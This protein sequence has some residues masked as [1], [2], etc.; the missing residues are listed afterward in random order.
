MFEDFNLKKQDMRYL[1]GLLIFNAI[2]VTYYINFNV[3]LGISCS[4]V[5][6]Y[7]LNALYFTGT[8]IH[9]TENIYLSPVVCF[10]TSLLFRCGLVDKLAIFIVTGLFAIFGNI[11]LY[12]LL[13]QFYDNTLSIAGSIIFSTLTLNL[14]WLANGTLDIPA[15]ALTIWLV[16]FSIIAIKKNPK[17]YTLAGLFFVLSVF[18]R[19]TVVLTIPALLIIYIYENG[20]KIKKEDKKHVFKAITISMV[21]GIIIF[22]TVFVMG[23][24]QFGGGQMLDRASGQTGSSTDPAFNPDYSYYLTNLPNFISNSHTVFDGNPVL[25]NPTVLSWTVI[26]ILIIGALLWLKDT[27]PKLE[28]K[29][30]IPIALFLISALIFTRI[31]SLVTIFLVSVGLYLLGKD[32]DNETGIAMFVWIISNIIF[33]TY[34]NIRVN[35]YIIPIFPAMIYFTI[36][37]ID[38]INSKI[39]INRNIIPIVL[40]VLF[41]VQGFAFKSTKHS[42]LQHS[43]RLPKRF[44]IIS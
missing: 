40:I 26:L 10:L 30:A 14:T 36:K 43:I 6:L 20:L 44:Q 19:Y 7:L 37:A 4:D 23:H 22:A 11:G 21:V 25:Q 16:L 9:A 5:Y 3:Q 42:S 41:A 33:F 31:T 29:H 8:N 32:S 39:R 17:F 18:T 34:L 1:L 27:K 24:G 12:L 38:I 28:K 13:K 2:L 35:R 15:V